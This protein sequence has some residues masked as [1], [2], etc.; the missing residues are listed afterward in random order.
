M[1]YLFFDD[2]SEG[3]HPK[4][5]EY[6]SKHNLDQQLGY[7]ADDYSKKAISNIRR[8]I[9]NTKADVHFVSG[10]TQANLVALASMLKSYEGVIA[11]TSGHIAVHEAGAIEATGHKIIAVQGKDGKLTKEAIDE[12]L[13]THQDEHSVVPKVMFLTQATELGTVYTLQELKE[14]SQYAKSKGLYVYL[15]GA[16]LAMAIGS[17]RSKMTLADIAR[18]VDMFYVGGTK[19]GGLLGE[20]VVIINDELKEGFRNHI[21]QRGALLAK[22]RVIGAQ[23]ARFFEEDQLWL[24]LGKEANQK[25]K[26]LYYGLEKFGIRFKAVPDANQIFPI[27]SN[28]IIQKLKKDYGFHVWEKSGSSDSVIRLVCS[29][30]TSE[31]AIQIFV[32]D[33]AEAD[34]GK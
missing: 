25:T 16:R 23:F 14:I 26:L 17:K 7:G 27:L 6:L 15:D 11:P 5:L 29:W 33:L 31:K 8:V 1:K 18:W 3:A 30:A 22:G 24:N 28:S 21:K 2:Y 19:N 9:K 32:K 10:G 34:D 20:A 4:I 12:G 13:A